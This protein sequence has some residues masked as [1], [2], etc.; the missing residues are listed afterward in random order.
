MPKCFEFKDSYMDESDE[1]VEV[2]FGCQLDSVQCDA[3]TKTGAACRKQAVIGLPFCYIHSKTYLRLE[4]RDSEIEGAG[5]G[6]FAYNPH[7]DHGRVFSRGQFICEYVGEVL[8]KD[9]VDERYGDTDDLTAPY[10]IQVSANRFLDAACRRG[11]A[12]V[13]NHSTTPNVQFYSYQG[14]IRCRATRNI[15]HGTELKANYR[16]RYHFQNNHRTYNCRK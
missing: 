7:A 10:V 1:E 13:I 12:G 4:V 14:R 6:V 15:N 8:T 3:E 5:K 16:A 2:E 11:I 9:E